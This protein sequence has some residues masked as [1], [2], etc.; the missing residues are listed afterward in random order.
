MTTVSNQGDDLRW[1]DHLVDAS[2]VRAWISSVL[3]EHPDVDGPT[4]VLHVKTRGVI[5]RFALR[6][7]YAHPVASSLPNTSLVPT[8]PP[9]RGTDVVFKASYISLYAH[10]PFVYELLGRCCA[11]NVP[12]LLAWDAGPGRMWTLFRPFEGVRVRE[13]NRLEPL[14]EVART[15]ARIQVAVA[16]APAAAKRRIARLPVSRI[17]V[18]FDEILQDIRATHLRVWNA[19]DGALAHKLNFPADPL[20]R[21]MSFRRH[22]AAWAAELEGGAWPDSIDHTDLHTGNA[23]LQADGRVLIYDWAEATIGSPFFSLEQLLDNA[24]A[25][26]T[27][28]APAQAQCVDHLGERSSTMAVRDAYLDALPWKTYSQRERALELAGYLWP[29]KDASICKSDMLALGQERRFSELTAV[30]MARALQRWES[31]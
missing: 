23:C 13:V 12:H 6:M 1:P 18:L 20:G 29:I 3:P 5:A 10:T 27:E 31:R 21:L 17:P 24:R 7:P 30:D 28:G 26:D 22:V 19:D 4:R 9:E 14:L 2:D 16:A 8:P 25:L 11:G 15:L